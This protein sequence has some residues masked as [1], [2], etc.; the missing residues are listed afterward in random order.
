MCSLLGPPSVL[1]S[2][3]TAGDSQR[4]GRAGDCG[5]GKVS[6]LLI[7][8]LQSEEGRAVTGVCVCGGER[9]RGGKNTRGEAPPPGPGPPSRV[10]RASGR[11]WAQNTVAVEGVGKQVGSSKQDSTDGN[12]FS[13]PPRDK[14][15]QHHETDGNRGENP[16]PV[17]SFTLPYRPL[18]AA[19]SGAGARNRGTG[20]TSPQA[21]GHV[22][23]PHPP[24]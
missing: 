23:Y 13:P 12:Q 15:A 19:D 20:V 18:P 16:G 9:K 5:H 22:P 7:D 1:S 21:G 24:V 3:R 14:H 2:V 10:G 17:F 6:S 4:A 11:Y 8:L